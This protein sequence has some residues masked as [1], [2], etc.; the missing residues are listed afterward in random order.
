MT[1][2]NDALKARAAAL[3]RQPPDEAKPTALAADRARVELERQKMARL[4]AERLAR[5]KRR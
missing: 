3:F 5:E 4:K 1:K 2:T